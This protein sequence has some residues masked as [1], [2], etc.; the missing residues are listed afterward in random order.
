MTA[1]RHKHP[2]FIAFQNKANAITSN[3][4]FLSVGEWIEIDADR[5]P[6]FNSEGG[7]AVIIAVHDDLADV[8]YVFLIRSFYF[9]IALPLSLFVKIRYVLTRRVEKL[10]PLRRFTIIIMPHCGPRASLRQQ[11]NPRHLRLKAKEAGA[12]QIS[13]RC[14]QFK[15]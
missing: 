6:G 9:T 3:L 1:V 13:G 8:K 10:V 12:S 5:T 2:W 7:I 14:L 4:K 15:F 11:K